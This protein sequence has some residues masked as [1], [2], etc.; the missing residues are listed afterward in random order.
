MDPRSQPRRPPGGLTA[1]AR[2]AL[3]RLAAK[4]RA[5]FALQQIQ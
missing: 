2:I 4:E 1:G 5:A 3:E